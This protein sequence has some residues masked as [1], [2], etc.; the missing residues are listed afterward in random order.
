M[1]KITKAMYTKLYRAY[2]SKGKITCVRG[3][4]DNPDSYF[5]SN[6]SFTLNSDGK[7]AT[8]K[9]KFGKQARYCNELMQ[10][11]NENHPTQLVG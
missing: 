4:S 10:Y 5:T 8:V 1:F 3:K 2:E 11:I 6:I 9:P 7:T